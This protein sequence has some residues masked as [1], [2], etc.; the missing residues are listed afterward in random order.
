MPKLSFESILY[1]FM[2]AVAVIGIAMITIGVITFFNGAP[3][4]T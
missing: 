1:V 4:C 3:G 2:F